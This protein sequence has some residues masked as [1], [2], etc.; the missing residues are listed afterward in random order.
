MT[1]FCR[2]AW[3]LLLLAW[4]VSNGWFCQGQVSHNLVGYVPITADKEIDFKYALRINKDGIFEIVADTYV[5][6]RLFG[7]DFNNETTVSLVDS[8]RSCKI[9]ERHSLHTLGNITVDDDSTGTVVV[10]VEHAG[11]HGTTYYFCF[12]EVHQ[13]TE[14]WKTLRIVKPYSNPIPLAARICFIG[15]LMVLSGLFSGL[16]LGLMALDVNSL[17]II[18]VSGTESQKRHAK[19]IYPVRKRGNYLLCTLLLGNVLVNSTFSILLGDLTTGLIAIAGSTFA[20]VIFG[21][22]IPQAICSRHGLFVGAKTIWL[23]YLFMIIT[24]PVSFPLS[25]ILDLILGEELGAI[26]NRDQLLHLLKV[27]HAKTDLEKDEVDIMTGALEFKKKT[28]ADVMTKISDVFC[29]EVNTFLNFR[30]IKQIYES[31]FSRIPVY[32]GN[33]NTVVGVLFLRDLAFIDPEDGVSLLSVLNFH[34]REIYS[35]FIDQKLDQTL[36]DFAAG[37][38]HLAIVNEIISNT[39]CDPFYKVVGVV[40]L[41]DILEEILQTEICDETDRFVD[42]RSLKPR[43][44][45]DVDLGGL[46]ATNSATPMLTPHQS[47]AIFQF[48]TSAVE[49]FSEEF[50]STSILKKL[51]QQ[52]VV[53]LMTFDEDNPQLL[54]TIGKP[55]NLFVLVIEG[56]VQVEVGHDKLQFSSRSFSHFGSRA[57]MLVTEGDNLEYIPDFSVEIKSDCRLLVVTQMQYRAAYRATRFERKRRKTP[58]SQSD[59]ENSDPFKTEWMYVQNGIMESLSPKKI[60]IKKKRSRGQKGSLSEE[61]VMLLSEEYD[62]SEPNWQYT[63]AEM[64]YSSDD[65]HPTSR[66]NVPLEPIAGLNETKM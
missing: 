20:I 27:T 64:H 23:T 42:N 25:K 8:T 21:E 7:T 17:Q 40:T 46:A 58:S 13:G 11:E 65:N 24:F 44:V 52:E 35:V 15:I 57:L 38:C 66:T 32:E 26:Y 10:H 30:T 1:P 60:R 39:D 22:I 29:L 55:S 9:N 61:S 16:N 54:Y 12:Y 28:V 49:P 2:F 3:T 33:K 43:N 37:K 51:L 63:S 53:K 19:T 45:K 41:E 56:T 4:I 31:G 50:I 18:M 48:L 5:T 47:L 36:N 34:K 62:D 14:P 6:I 59:Q